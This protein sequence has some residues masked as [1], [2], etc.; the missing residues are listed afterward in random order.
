MSSNAAL[1]Q[2]WFIVVVSIT[3][4]IL[5]TTSPLEQNSFSGIDAVFEAMSAFATVGV[6]AGVTGITSEISQV[7]LILAMFIG[8]VGPVSF[9]LSLAAQQ[10]VSRKLIMPEG[11]VIVG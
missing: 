1:Q 10:S 3:S 9:G 6:S 11:K 5:M 4:I 7:A 8:R 2:M